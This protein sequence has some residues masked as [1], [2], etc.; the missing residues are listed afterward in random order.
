MLY[1]IIVNTFGFPFGLPFWPP[2]LASPMDLPLWPPLREIL[3]TQLHQCI[4][5][6]QTAVL[7]IRREV[8]FVEM[9]EKCKITRRNETK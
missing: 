5:D 6:E 2:L 9:I 1:I 3:Y 8:H 4:K 7:F